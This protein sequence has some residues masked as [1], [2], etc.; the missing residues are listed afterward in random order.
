MVAGA[1]LAS[2]TGV[3]AAK[4]GPWFDGTI[5]QPVALTRLA[6]PVASLAEA[7]RGPADQGAPNP[8]NSP[9]E[10]ERKIYSSD[11]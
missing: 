7:E 9:W 8:E 11:F 1:H 2:K 4:M 6:G 10:V 3:V 5:Q